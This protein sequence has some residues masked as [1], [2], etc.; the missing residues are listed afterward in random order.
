MQFSRRTQFARRRTSALAALG[1]TALL[2]F[3]ALQPVAAQESCSTR[4]V[5]G[6]FA[7]LAQGQTEDLQHTTAN[8]GRIMVDGR[9]GLTGSLTLS[10]NGQIAR[11]QRV[12]GTYVVNA[13][14][15][16]TEQF[17]IGPDPT[18]RTADFVIADHG[19]EI[20]FLETDTGTVFSGS[21][22]RQ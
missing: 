2:G 18:L 20:E 11:D 5:E 9:G 7:L 15:T 22:T 4:T 17:T 10:V 12:R 19:R 16:G 8:L 1:V 3:A 6:E 13:D 14:C 21:A